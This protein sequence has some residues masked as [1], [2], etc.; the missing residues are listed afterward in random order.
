ME[1]HPGTTMNSQGN[2]NVFFYL[3]RVLQWHLISN[4][5][6]ANYWIEVVHNSNIRLCCIYLGDAIPLQNWVFACCS[7]KKHV[8]HENQC[9]TRNKGG[10]IQYHPKVWEIMP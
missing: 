3:I 5:C 7:N 4:G 1:E 8:V 10:G 6:Y 2:C 9:G